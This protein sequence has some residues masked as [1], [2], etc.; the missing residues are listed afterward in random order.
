MQWAS[1]IPYLL[2]NNHMETRTYQVYTYAEL[3]KEAKEKALKNYHDINTEYDEWSECSTSYWAEKLAKL[4]Y[5]DAKV[6][7]SGFW[8]QGDGACFTA[9]VDL[10]QWLKAHKLTKKYAYLL[11][12]CYNA[13]YTIKHTGHYSHSLSTSVDYELNYG[14]DAFDEDKAHKLAGEVCTLIEAEREK[15]GDQIYKD[16]E[17]DYNDLSSDD[18]IVATFEANDYVFTLDGKID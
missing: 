13:T 1:L 14:S 6:L 8:S 2:T 16:L 17:S 7:F 12:H 11:K 5:N 15:L 4:G 9:T 10:P 18:A 3:P